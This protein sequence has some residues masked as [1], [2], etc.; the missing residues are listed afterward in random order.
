MGRKLERQLLKEGVTISYAIDRSIGDVHDGIKV[1]HPSEKKPKVDCII[2]TAYEQ[3]DIKE[4]LLKNKETDKA[5]TIQEL[6]ERR[7]EELL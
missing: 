3:N 4:D 6:L 5:Y 2:V 1:Y 7:Y